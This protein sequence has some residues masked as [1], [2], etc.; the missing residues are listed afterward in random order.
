M[1]TLQLLLASDGTGHVRDHFE[2]D[3]PGDAIA[4]GEAADVAPAVFVKS[5]EEIRSDA[6]IDG[7]TRLA[8]EDVD[9]GLLAH[10]SRHPELISGSMLTAEV[11]VEKWMLKQVQH[12][13]VRVG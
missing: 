2:S 6:D 11:S 13:R 9:S 7:A 12:D 8:S 1:P 3:Q 4:R 5:A 10:S